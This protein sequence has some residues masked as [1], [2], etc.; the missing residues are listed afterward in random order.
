MTRII[1]QLFTIIIL[2]TPSLATA[3][4]ITED[5]FKVKKKEY[6]KSLFG[7]RDYANDLEEK[8]PKKTKR[9]EVKL[10]RL[11]EAIE[12]RRSFS[13]KIFWA[14]V[15][16]GTTVLIL[17]LQRNFDIEDDLDS[18]NFNKP[19]QSGGPTLMVAGVGIAALSYLYH[20]K[21]RNDDDL[22]NK[23]IK[24]EVASTDSRFDLACTN[25]NGK[26]VPG[27]S[28]SLRF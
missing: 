17:G 18:D 10:D 6:R 20:Y 24:K 26:V 13:Q 16:T 14:G 12:E 25:Y 28:W 8:S 1:L 5:S 23:F 9:F 19:K 27:F 4:T 22:V 11:E 21:W 2:V 15:A 7:L 3:A